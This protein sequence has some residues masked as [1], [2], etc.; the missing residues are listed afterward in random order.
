[1]TARSIVHAARY[2]GGI[3][4][5][6][7]AVAAIVLALTAAAGADTA[8]ATDPSALAVPAAG[9]SATP[10]PA[11]MSAPP[12]AE[13]TVDEVRQLWRR[14]EFLGAGV[15][16]VFGL[17]VIALRVDPKR[18]LYYTAGVT[19]LGGCVDLV[20]N[21]QTPNGGML[22]GAVAVFAAL[23]TRSPL[24]P[25]T[26]QAERGSAVPSLLAILAGAAL[27]VGAMGAWSCAGAKRTASAVKDAVI[28]CAKLTV[29][30]RADEYADRV[31]AAIIAGTAANGEVSWGPAKREIGGILADA[32]LEVAGC[33]AGLAV[34]R[35]LYPTAD[36]PR[37]LVPAPE[38]SAAQVRD[39]W[40]ATRAEMLG[41]RR[42]QVQVG[43]L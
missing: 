15:L 14:G 5:A 30:Q 29:E 7:I 39:G 32:G 12:A 8:G 3:L 31:E 16:V 20:A 11:I 43:A 34:A 2:P 21:G 6:S 35:I 26:R 22:V 36:R 41:G 37:G 33:A 23:V 40:D 10:A 1:M 42:F 18:A 17:L 25:A 28:D 4:L 19:A 27:T 9:D 13:P 38:P 24:P